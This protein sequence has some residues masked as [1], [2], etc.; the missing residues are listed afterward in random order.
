MRMT[1]PE[2]ELDIENLKL[3]MKAVAERINQFN[4]EFKP[5]QS[6]TTEPQNE[7]TRTQI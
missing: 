4:Q 2:F 6:T 1:S 3:D 5:F 7:P